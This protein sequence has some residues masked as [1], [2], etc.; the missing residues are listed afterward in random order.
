MLTT[1]RIA[2]RALT[3]NKLR[4]G[5]TVLGVVIGIAAVTAMVSIGQSAG[6]MVQGQFE[7]IGANIIVIFPRERREG[8]VNRARSEMLTL[9]ADDATAMSRECPS[10]L[11]ASPMMFAQA[12]LVFQRENWTPNEMHGVGTEYLI[13]R[14]W[15]L[16]SGGFFSQQD[17]DF[18]A[19]V[20]VLGHTVVN[21]LFQTTNPLGKM[22][23]IK[24]IP[25]RV[26]GVLAKKG[27]NIVGED[28]DNIVLLPYSTVQ[29]RI[30]G[31]SRQRVHM[32]MASAVSPKQSFDAQV[33]I[34]QILYQ[35]HRIPPGQPPD[36][37]IQNTVEISRILGIVTGTLTAMLSTI[38][39]ISL[40]VGGVG[41]MNIMLVSVT[42]RTREIGIR[43][44][45]GA[46]GRDILRQFLV[47]S[48][49]LATFG[50]LIGLTLGVLASIGVTT[51]INEILP[52]SDWPIIVSIPAAIIAI[53]FAAA[54]GMF[55][56][57]WPAWRASQLDPI[58]ALRYE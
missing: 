19:T 35:R 23:R 9:T 51:A 10:V 32:V 49:L 25:F 56:G 6:A 42:E 16:E 38:A 46:R 31:A 20:C 43:M 22:I 28:Q 5:L 13:A 41:I 27:A 39:G 12:Q 11:A 36:F 48:V 55:F 50:G 17:I 14:N 3:K 57:F 53:I 30:Y 18:A 45:V 26:I 1:F 54:V 37:E 40:L 47:E 15:P 29:K 33:E 21:K 24:N 52:G 4:A 44:A 7:S 58:E 2:F 8:G 34:E